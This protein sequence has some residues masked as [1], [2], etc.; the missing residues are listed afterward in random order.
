VEKPTPDAVA[1]LDA[2]F[3]T[4]PRASRKLMF[5]TNAGIIEGG[6]S[7]RLGA[8]RVQALIE[9]HPGVA[10]FQPGGRTWPE[11]ALVDGTTWKGTPELS[12]WVREALD[13]TAT[14]PAKTPKPKKA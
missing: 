8:A 9:A 5:G 14:M 13:Y 6:V 12:G 2:A 1:A 3:P 4:D 10:P 7:L 11:Y